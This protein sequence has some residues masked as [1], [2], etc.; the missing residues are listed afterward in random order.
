MDDSIVAVFKL[1]NLYRFQFCI[2]NNIYGLEKCMYNLDFLTE[3]K[4]LQEA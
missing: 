2:F 4:W 3:M 1:H